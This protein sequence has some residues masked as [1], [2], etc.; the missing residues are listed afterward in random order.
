MQAQPQTMTREELLSC[1]FQELV[2]AQSNGAAPAAEQLM[3][4]IRKVS[5]P[6]LRVAQL[7]C[8]TNPLYYTVAAGDLQD[9]QPSQA[10]HA[11]H[12]LRAPR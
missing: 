3:G 6:E 8:H 11:V 12:A 9:A 2:L 4:Q 1:S 5:L 10:H 7:A